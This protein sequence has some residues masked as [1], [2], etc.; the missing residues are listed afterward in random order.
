[1]K[2]NIKFVIRVMVIHV[3]TY[4]L[5]GVVFSALFD[6]TA[7]YQQ[8]NINTFMRA[9]GSASSLIGPVMQVVRGL[10]FGLILLLLKDSIIGKKYGWPKLWAIIVGIG[11]INT[12]GPTPCSIEGIIYTQLPLEFHI[13][14]APEILLQTLLFSL[15]V[16]NPGNF[17][18]PGLRENKIP[19]IS[20]VLAGVMFSLSGVILSLILHLEMTAGITDIGAF[21]IMF[22]AVI[23]VFLVCKWYLSTT[24]RLKHL[25]LPLCCYTV[26]AIMPV[27]YNYMTRS[28]FAS[29]LPL[30]INVI[31]VI[32]IFLLNYMGALHNNKKI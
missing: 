15:F 27:V 23:S 25:V 8:E 2:E 9:V 19:L 17:I 3:L 13:K 14:A 28:L 12:P 29:W 7:L 18:F 4:L 1:M 20:T 32:I 24:S 30:G 11:I 21:V 26:L 6:Y 31:P 5:C 16:A 10:L 22:V